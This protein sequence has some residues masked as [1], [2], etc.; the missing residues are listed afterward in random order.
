[1]TM[2]MIDSGGGG[3]GGVGSGMNELNNSFGHGSELKLVSNMIP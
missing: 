1:M 3:G 2:M